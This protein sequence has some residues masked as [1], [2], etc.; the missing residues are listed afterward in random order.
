MLSF[1][2]LLLHKQPILTIDE[3]KLYIALIRKFFVTFLKY[4][5]IETITFNCFYSGYPM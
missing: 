4:N 1:N 2:I 5:L 3:L